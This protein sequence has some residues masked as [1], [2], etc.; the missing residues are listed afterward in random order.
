MTSN[1][2][3]VPMAAAPVV[4]VARV[5]SLVLKA[6]H[7]QIPALKAVASAVLAG[8]VRQ[9]WVTTR[10]RASPPK[11]SSTQKQHLCKPLWLKTALRVAVISQSHRLQHLLWCPQP[12]PLTVW[13]VK[14][15]ILSQQSAMPSMTTP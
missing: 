8:I 11:S 13:T 14:Q 4:K 5:V 6:K 10:H 3:L 15:P 2:L 7:V 1:V 9:A 12:P